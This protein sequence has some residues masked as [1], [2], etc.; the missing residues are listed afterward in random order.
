VETYRGI[1]PYDETKAYVTQVLDM[2][3]Q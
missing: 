3:K 2:L 1:P